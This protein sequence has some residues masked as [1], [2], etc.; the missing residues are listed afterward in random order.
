M[1]RAAPVLLH[2]TGRWTTETTAHIQH[3]MWQCEVTADDRLR[4]HVPVGCLPCGSRHIAH[5]CDGISPYGVGYRTLST[6]GG[7]P[8]TARRLHALDND[9]VVRTRSMTTNAI[10][11]TLAKVTRNVELPCKH[12]IARLRI[13]SY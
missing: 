7:H 12:H 5:I 6:C 11:N 13:H 8:C 3:R 1:L 4:E 10:E 2:C 9:F